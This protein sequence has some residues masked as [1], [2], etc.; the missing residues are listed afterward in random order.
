MSSICPR[1][2]KLFWFH[3]L[4]VFDPLPPPPPTIIFLFYSFFFYCLFDFFL[5][6]GKLLLS[7]DLL[8]KKRQEKKQKLNVKLN[9]STW[10]CIVFLLSREQKP[11]LSFHTWNKICNRNLDLTYI[12]RDC[13]T[14]NF[15][16][17]TEWE[18]VF[19]LL[20]LEFLTL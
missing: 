7:F 20:F 13:K 12:T 16:L 11:L 8:V 19:F 6:T 17:I 14:G 1:K 15:L 9:L 4:I 10:S 2:I 5:C 18:K 3:C